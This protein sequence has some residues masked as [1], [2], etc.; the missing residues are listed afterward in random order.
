MA[1]QPN[2]PCVRSVSAAPGDHRFGTNAHDCAL[3][4]LVTRAVHF[5]PQS[6]I[7][8]ILSIRPND[9]LA[10]PRAF[11]VIFIRIK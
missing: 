9:R 1:T 7:V 3:C 8:H 10:W 2:L 5:W 4:V 6:I 11:V